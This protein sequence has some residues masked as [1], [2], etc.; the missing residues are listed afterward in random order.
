M[1]FV[2]R[3]RVKVRIRFGAWFVVMVILPLKPINEVI[4]VGLSS[5][6][7]LLGFPVCIYHAQWTQSHTCI[8]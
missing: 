4:F 8:V 3:I 6:E 5:I 7:A 2:S 1:L